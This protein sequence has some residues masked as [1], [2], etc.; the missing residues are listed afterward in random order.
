MEGIPTTHG[1]LNDPPEVEGSLLSAGR[2]HSHDEVSPC[3]SSI[4]ASPQLNQAKH[5]VMTEG[6]ST[7]FISSKSR[8]LF[9]V[10]TL[11]V[12]SWWKVGR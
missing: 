7:L 10:W 2:D 3:R 12:V 9:L 11:L 5:L 4:E 6:P 8:G 1:T